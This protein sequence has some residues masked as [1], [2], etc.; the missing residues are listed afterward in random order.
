MNLGSI[1]SQVKTG[2]TVMFRVY[3]SSMKGRVENGDEVTVMPVPGDNLRKGDVVLA[4]V[5]GRWMLHLISAFGSNGRRVQISNN[6]GRINGWTARSNVV[7]V[8]C[9]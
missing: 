6:H 5:N 1:A 2:Q 3:G 8:L 7:G 4:R 9:D